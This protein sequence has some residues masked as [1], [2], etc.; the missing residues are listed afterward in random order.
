MKI[1]LITQ[2]YKPIKAAAS[3]R[4]SRMAEYL[5]KKGH[6]L[7]VLT[8]MPSYPTGILP[9]KYK[10]KLTFS[11]KI[12][13]V[14][15]FRVYEYPAPNQGV[16][17][18][19]FNNFSFAASAA[20]KVIFGQKYDAVIVSSPSF[21]AGIPG[22]FAKYRGAKLY[23]DIRDLWP[24]SAF[25]LGFGN[26]GMIRKF[27]LYLEKCF[28]KNS[29]RILTATDSIKKHLIGE[30][31]PEEKIVALLNTVDT[32]KYQPQKVS[33]ADF[34]F[35]ETDFIVAYTGIHGPAQGLEKIIETAEILK[36]KKE[37][38][39]LFVGEGEEKAKLKETAHQKGLTN[40]I[41]WDEK[42]PEE[43]VNIVNMA[44]IGNISLSSK[45]IFQ[46]AIPTKAHEYLSC[47]K[48]VIAGVKGDLRAYINEYDAGICYEASDAQTQ[49]KAIIDLY[50]KKDLSEM[51]SN[52]RRLALEVFSDKV[53]F[54]TLDELFPLK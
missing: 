37:I 17:K 16:L 38:K 49:A 32:E 20:L 36:D 40:V 51:A 21:L 30:N 47:G 27:L 23:F 31:W 43:I 50:N 8:G 14:D 34:G 18:R 13:G 48:P 46:E 3:K 2:W 28:Y 39:F 10:G 15:V 54:K 5:T 7:T 9:E 1:L 12:D 6:N 35:K 41:F 45:K 19:L 42:T 22:V 52:A 25:E 4:T 29:Y 33:K 44:D 26:K 53:F 11:E 24:D